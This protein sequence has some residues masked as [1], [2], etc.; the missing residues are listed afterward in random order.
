MIPKVNVTE[1]IV[2]PFNQMFAQGV[3]FCGAKL[4]SGSVRL[5]PKD[6]QAIINIPISNL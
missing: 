5:E 1:T 4:T 6:N 3:C 2:L